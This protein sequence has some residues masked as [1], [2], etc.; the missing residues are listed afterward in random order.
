MNAMADIFDKMREVAVRM[1]TN[2]PSSPH[3]QHVGRR[4]YHETQ[5]WFRSKVGD[6][7]ATNL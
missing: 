6:Y 2:D 1:H 4:S 7:V 3:V 5:Q